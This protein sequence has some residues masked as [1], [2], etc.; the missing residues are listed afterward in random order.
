M[1]RFTFEF[2]GRQRGALGINSHFVVTVEAE[3]EEDARLKLYDTHEH[4]SV[5]QTKENNNA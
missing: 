3:T 4:I 2:I 1:K 5:L